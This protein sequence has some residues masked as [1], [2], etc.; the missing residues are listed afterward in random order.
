M[1][2]AH[3]TAELLA[4]YAGG[5]LSDGMRLIVE[6]HLTF[7]PRCRSR[8][9]RLESLGGALLCD[10]AEAEPSPSCLAGALA[11]LDKHPAKDAPIYEEP[12]CPLPAPLRRRIGVP[13]SEIRW[14]SSMPG[15]LEHRLDGFPAEEVRLLRAPP[16][17]Q[18]LQHTHEGEE[19]TLVLTGKLRD[20][21]R[22]F[23]RGDVSLADAHDDHS[24]EVI[25][26]EI[27][28]CLLVL[29]GPIR[30]TGRFARILDTPA[31]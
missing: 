8:V 9:R 27:C 5:S 31:R 11:R 26:S 18:I 13:L 28:L 10:G 25:G 22:I 23:S 17:R 3:A 19:A 12:G 21:G 29:S 24:P 30:F 4:S 15:I 14:R 7:C 20:G 6:S 1:T 2:T 16:G